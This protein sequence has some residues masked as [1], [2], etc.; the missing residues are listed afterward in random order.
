MTNPLNLFHYTQINNNN[1]LSI[2]L[3][4]GTGGTE[5]DLFPLVEPF[6]TSHTIVGLRGNIDESGMARFFKRTANGTFDQDSIREEADK[7]VLFIIAWKKEHKATANNILYIGY[8]NGA[9]IILATI[10]Y[11]PEIIKTAALLHPMLPFHPKSRLDLSQ[12]KLYLSWSRSDSI[13]PK[14][15]SQKVINTLNDFSANTTIV[16]TT[17]GHTITEPEIKQLHKFVANR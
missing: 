3:F 7:L 13:I 6:H 17:Q 15:A 8:S 4:H 12:H 5:T 9:N 16:E 2:F 1:P 10:F 14:S 11:Y